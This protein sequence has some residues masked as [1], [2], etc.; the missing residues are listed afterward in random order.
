M[1]TFTD[2]QHRT[3]E[4]LYRR[5]VPRIRRHACSDYLV[6]FELLDL[7]TREI[8][9][10][11]FLNSRITP[12]TGWKVIRTEVR[13]S[14]ADKWYLHFQEREFLVTDYIRS[15]EEL[16]WTPEPDMFHDIFGHLP[17]MMLRQYTA[18]QEMFAPAY[19]R[20]TSDEQRESIKKLAW[21][22]TEFGL[23]RENGERK[24]F[25]T[26]LMSGGD[27][28]DNAVSG[29]VPILPFRIGDVLD[30]EKAVDEQNQVL[31]ELASI[32]SLRSELQ[33]YFATL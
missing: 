33:S 32:D 16:D 15:W 12:A 30:H 5:Q 4:E 6:G 20:A 26:G 1:E 14:D 7:P 29:K 24:V 8:P 28:M 10:V 21:F 13:Y 19:W 9:S 31:F 23:V 2:A 17:F 22:T 25:G 3:W 18:L 27:E 11:Q